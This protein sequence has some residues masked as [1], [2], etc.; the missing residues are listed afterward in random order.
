MGTSFA[1]DYSNMLKKGK[2]AM[3]AYGIEYS[4]VE[5]L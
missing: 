2:L 1:I 3:I 4:L 5:R